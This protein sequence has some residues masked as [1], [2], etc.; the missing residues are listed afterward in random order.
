MEVEFEAVF[1]TEIEIEGAEEASRTGTGECDEGCKR[2]GR[3]TEAADTGSGIGLEDMPLL[4]IVLESTTTVFSA[5]A[6]LM[7]RSTM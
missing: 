5:V 2:G 4:L 1:D 3:G 7:E 6:S